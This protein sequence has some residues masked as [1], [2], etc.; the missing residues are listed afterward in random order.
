MATDKDI[1][2]LLNSA[3]I[4]IIERFCSKVMEELCST[5]NL[6]IKTMKANGSCK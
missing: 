6:L 1:L 3:L 4:V 2:D 5:A